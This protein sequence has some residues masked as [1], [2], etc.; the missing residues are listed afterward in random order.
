MAVGAAIMLCFSAAYFGSVILT[1]LYF[2]LARGESATTSGLL[3]IPQAVATGVS[4]QIAGRLLDRVPAG[5]VVAAGVAMAMT[6]FGLFAI[7]LGPSTSY[8]ALTAALSLAGLGVGATLMPTIATATRHLN[9]DDT[10]SGATVINIISQVATAIGAAAVSVLLAGRLAIRLPALDADLGTLYA[11]PTN[12]RELLAEPL[13]A[14]F[15]GTYALPVALMGCALAV[16]TMFLVRSPAPRRR[17]PQHTRER[18][19]T[20]SGPPRQGPPKPP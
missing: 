7:L 17:P 20:S 18:R 8:V 4:M 10:P 3:L 6:G 12:Q 13:T 16:A 2:Q 19:P 15:Q 14:A 9:H 11:M 5:R 1:P